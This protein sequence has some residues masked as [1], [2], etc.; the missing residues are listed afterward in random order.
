[1]TAGKIGV[2]EPKNSIF[3]RQSVNEGIFRSHLDAIKLFA[4]LFVIKDDDIV[5][6]VGAPDAVVAFKSESVKPF[7]FY[8]K[9]V[10]DFE[11]VGEVN[12]DDGFGAERGYPQQV[13]VVVPLDAVDAAAIRSSPSIYGLASVWID[14]YDVSKVGIRA[15]IRA[16]Y[17]GA[18][19][20]GPDMSVA[21]SDARAVL[22][23][24]V[25]GSQFV[26][27]LVDDVHV[28]G[29]LVHHIQLVFVPLEAVGH[30]AR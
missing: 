7:E 10:D 4:A 30:L 16:R 23:G 8:L 22:G 14:L 19:R 21:D 18:V 15:S 29:E 5:G 12:E 24:G 3:L 20:P 26:A 6:G 11:V 25:D 28:V 1:M 2:S 9:L 13:L 27:G 17:G